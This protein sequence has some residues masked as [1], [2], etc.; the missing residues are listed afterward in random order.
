VADQFVEGGT[1]TYMNGLKRMANVET[2]F[3]DLILADQVCPGGREACF[4]EPSGG[5][6]YA[7]TAVQSGLLAGITSVHQ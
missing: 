3:G 7:Q 4:F 5:G 1:F 2:K 6:V